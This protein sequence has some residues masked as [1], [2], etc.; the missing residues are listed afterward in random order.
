MTTAAKKTIRGQEM[1]TRARV[2]RLVQE[3]SLGAALIVFPAR[4]PGSMSA[5]GTGWSLS[6]GRPLAG[7]VG[8]RDGVVGAG[9]DPPSVSESSE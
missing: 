5:I 6:S 2:F 9:V 3:D 1:R 4:R 8:R 7:P